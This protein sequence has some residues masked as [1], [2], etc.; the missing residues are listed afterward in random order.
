MPNNV[1]TWYSQEL[2]QSVITPLAKTI[3]SRY[4][5]K[6]RLLLRDGNLVIR[7][8]RKNDLKPVIDSTATQHIVESKEAYRPDIIAYNLYGNPNLAWVILSANNLSDVFD[9]EPNMIINVPSAISLYR[10]GGVMS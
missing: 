5:S 9:L 1:D 8:M 3:Y 7:N 4:D 10:T 2:V 6:E